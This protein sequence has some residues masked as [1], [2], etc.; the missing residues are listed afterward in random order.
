[1]VIKRFELVNRNKIKGIKRIF[2][3]KY[4]GDWILLKFELEKVENGWRFLELEELKIA[5]K[6]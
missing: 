6:K 1:M 4:S 3:K 5:P 2:P